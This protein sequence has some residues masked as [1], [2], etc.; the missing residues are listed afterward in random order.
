VAFR[1]KRGRKGFEKLAPEARA[2][3]FYAENAGY[4]PHF[5]PIIHELTETMGRE[6]C[7]LTSS[8]ADPIL[9]LGNA[10]IH[11]FEIGE[12]FGRA[13]LFQTMEVGVLVA[14]VPQLGIKVLPRSKRAAA[15]GTTYV[16]VFHSMVSTHMVYEPDGFD[17]YD[18]VLCAG[19]Y[20]IDEIRARETMASLPAKELIPHG[21]GR[22]DAILATDQPP[23]PQSADVPV[24]LLAPSWGPSCVFETCG[25]DLV[26][27][28]LDAGYHV[29]ARPHPMTAK[30]SPKAIPALVAQ[31]SNHPRFELDAD[32]ASQA[33]LHRSDVMVSDWSG[34][35]LE[36]AFGLERPVLFIDVPRKVNNG[37]YEKLGIEPFEVAIRDEIGRVV[38]VGDLGRAPMVASELIADPAG[39]AA[40]I[41]AT[42]DT[43]VFNVG[44]SGRVAADVIADKADA[45]L[46]RRGSRV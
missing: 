41:R 13:L 23:R 38:G 3:T 28:F 45:Y 22:L 9:E 16:Y 2:I 5:E 18:T 26:R 21:Y 42:R 17:H 25:A 4:W 8:S 29:I 15:V 39:F 43:S 24:V 19:P 46:R 11:A 1:N 33:S 37:E 36:Y 31:F 6:I 40:K 14:T 10:R 34:A 30:R 44:S 20:M 32:V 35:A 7:Y 12:G 27:A